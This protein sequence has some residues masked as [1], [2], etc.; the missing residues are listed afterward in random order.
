MEQ[1][2]SA[3]RDLARR[4]L[5]RE[6]G[7][8]E[9]AG[10]R[11]QA[12]LRASEKLRAHLSKLVGV[13]G[14]QALLARALA[15]AKAEVAWLDAVRVQPDGSLEGFGETARKQDAHEARKGEVA[16]LAQLLGLLV[17]FIGEALTLRLLQDVWP[18]ASPNDPNA[19]GEE[20]P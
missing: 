2:T 18:D 7:E 19:I 14:F 11:G 16:L 20:T 3:V 5:A 4:L 8:S 13:A 12:A 6:A 9:P 1:T 15:L 10:T 17:T